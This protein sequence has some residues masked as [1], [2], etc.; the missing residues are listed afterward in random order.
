MKNTKYK[1]IHDVIV[2]LHKIKG[3]EPDE[4]ADEIKNISKIGVTKYLRLNNLLLSKY[5]LIKIKY[6]ERV[7]ELRNR[8]NSI[9]DIAASLNISILFTKRI[10]EDEDAVDNKKILKEKKDILVGMVKQGVRK[11]DAS[12]I[13]NI[14][15]PGTLLRESVYTKDLQKILEYRKQGLSLQKIVDELSYGTKQSLSNYLNNLNEDFGGSIYGKDKNLILKLYQEDLKKIP[16]IISILKYGSVKSLKHYLFKKLNIH[17][18]KNIE[19]HKLYKMKDVIEDKYNEGETLENIA[20]FCDSEYW[21]IQ[22]FITQMKFEREGKTN[23]KYTKYNAEIFKMME[24]IVPPIE[25]E[26]RLN[27]KSTKKDFRDYLKNVLKYDY[28]RRL[29]NDFNS[30]KEQV[31]LLLEKNTSIRKIKTQLDIKY[32]IS[33]LRLKINEIKSNKE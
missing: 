22:R 12:K 14:D 20:R 29:Q 16:E 28:C 7:V 17:K 24:D 9:K 8:G 4:I 1:K 25:I 13:L 32:D 21:E 3:Y 31:K 5:E 18:K 26:A 30:K 33:T 19:Y 23:S 10:L 27:I 2:E 6:K 11:E 15:N